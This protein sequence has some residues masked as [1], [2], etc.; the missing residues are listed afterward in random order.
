MLGK[1]PDKLLKS[2]VQLLVEAFE[3]L[4]IPREHV[5]AL[6]IP[7]EDPDQVGPITNPPRWKVFQPSPR[8]IGQE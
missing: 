5:C 3:V 8:Q 4:G 6:K 7:H 2:L 1:A